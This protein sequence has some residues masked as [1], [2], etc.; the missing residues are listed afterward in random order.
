MSFPFLKHLEGH[1]L[2]NTKIQMPSDLTKLQRIMDIA[3]EKGVKIHFP[4]DGV[5]S[6]TLTNTGD[7]ITCLN[8]DVPEGY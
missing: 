5:C 4:V 2:G 8:K 7:T 6:K 3:K 1:Q